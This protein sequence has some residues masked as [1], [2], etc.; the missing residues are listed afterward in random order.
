MGSRCRQ[1]RACVAF[2]CKEELAA[3][4]CRVGVE[5]SQQRGEVER[6]RRG[7]VAGVQFPELGWT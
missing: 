6:G 1:P 4:V 5:K 7:V 3:F 2:S